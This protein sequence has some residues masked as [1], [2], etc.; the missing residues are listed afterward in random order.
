[1][2]VTIRLPPVLTD[3][4]TAYSDAPTFAWHEVGGAEAY[5]VLVAGDAGFSSPEMDEIVAGTD[6]TPASEFGGGTYT[7]RVRAV[8]GSEVGD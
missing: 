3:G 7:W 6:Y 1:M 5:R 4:S 2:N 8:S